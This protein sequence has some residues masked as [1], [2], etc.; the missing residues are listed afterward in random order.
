[1]SPNPTIIF[2]IIGIVVLIAAVGFAV[3]TVICKKLFAAR[4][5][6]PVAM[7]LL[8]IICGLASGS[9]ETDGAAVFRIMFLASASA[10][11]IF[12]RKKSKEG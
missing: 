1:M 10:F 4:Y 2:L 7:L 3:E 8:H 9:F 6:F 5:V 11:A 12:G